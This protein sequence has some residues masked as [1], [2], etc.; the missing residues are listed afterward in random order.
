MSHS[1]PHR[2]RSLSSLDPDD[3]RALRD[4][5]DPRHHIVVD[6]I[7]EWRIAVLPHG[8]PRWREQRAR[9]ALDLMLWNPHH[10]ATLVTPSRATDGKAEV[11]VGRWVGRFCGVACASRWLIE[12]HHLTVPHPDAVHRAWTHL[13]LAHSLTP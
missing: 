9:G 3:L 11:R 8:G 13:V 4:R 12:E 5:H 6:T 2:P 7:G 1:A 10:H